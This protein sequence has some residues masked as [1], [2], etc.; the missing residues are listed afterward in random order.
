MTRVQVLDRDGNVVEELECPEFRLVIEA[1][2]RRLAEIDA[3]NNVNWGCEGGHGNA[4]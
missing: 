2:E 4:E 1:Q 3:E